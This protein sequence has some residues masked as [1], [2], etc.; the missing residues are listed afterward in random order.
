M[1]SLCGG[2]PGLAGTSRRLANSVNCRTVYSPLPAS[3][4]APHFVSWAKSYTGYGQLVVAYLC[5]ASAPRSLVDMMFTSRPPYRSVDRYRNARPLGRVG[6]QNSPPTRCLAHTRST[7][8]TLLPAI[9]DHCSVTAQVGRLSLVC[10]QGSFSTS[11]LSRLLVAR[12][13]SSTA[14]TC[15]SAARAAGPQC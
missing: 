3:Q 6:K 1:A 2:I 9:A 10:C 13:I 12:Q 5:H 14:C 4:P 11:D 7:S 8:R 15:Q